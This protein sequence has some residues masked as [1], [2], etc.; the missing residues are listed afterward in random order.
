MKKGTFIKLSYT[1]KTKV[2]NKIFDKGEINIISGAGYVISGL[3]ESFEKHEIG[4]NYSI[5][6][7]C[8]KAFGKRN[9]NLLKLIPI[10]EF[11]KQKINP[12]PGL[13]LTI[14]DKQGLVRSVSGGRV[15]VDFNNPLAGKDVIYDVKILK[16][17]KEDKEK[18]KTVIKARLGIPETL[19]AIEK[20]KVLIKGVKK[21]FAKELEKIL[22]KD[23][24]T[25]ANLKV[26]VKAEKIE[27]QKKKIK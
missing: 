24:E 27:A 25:Y 20:N 1:A 8:E 12:V 21:E 23:L 10:K 11:K 15:I 4:D 22:N 3:D 17:I 18:I 9:P 14:N 5:E 19:Y 6:I 13:V 16:E 26:E 2:N 7:P